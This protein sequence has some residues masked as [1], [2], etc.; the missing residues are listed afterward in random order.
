MELGGAAAIAAS[1]ATP[2]PRTASGAT[3]PAARRAALADG[4]RPEINPRSA[5]AGDLPVTGEIVPEEDVRFLLVHHTASTNEYGPED[6]T[7]Q[8]RGFYSFHTGPEKGW[9]DVAYNFF[10]DRFGG[11]WE[12][13]AGSLAGPV[14]GDATGG[15]QGHALLCSLIGDHRTAEVTA[16]AKA[17]MTGLLAWL[18]V[19][20]GV[21]PTPGTTV[22]F[23]S[24]GSNRWPAGTE[25]TART[26]SGHR[27]MS[28][29]TCPGDA[30]YRWI[31]DE[32]PVAV[33]T[34]VAEAAAAN[35]PEPTLVPPPQS[36]TSVPA[37]S[38][39]AASTEPTAGESTT[40]DQQALSPSD[41]DDD[42]PFDGVDGRLA[43]LTG[44]AAAVGAVI[45]AALVRLRGRASSDPT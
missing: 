42:S 19:R 20:H 8:I 1:L 23:V 27:D 40:D 3:R 15:S 10:V 24:R 5:W 30:A 14:R 37:P 9:P 25:V 18:S 12:A 16:A 7:D 31:G 44:G 33:T 29:T 4:L 43:A 17:A 32:L 13:R 26:I 21:D 11:I 41:Q 6:V 45:T 2:L 34:A 36:T 35:D 28:Q 22:D 38:T 39:T